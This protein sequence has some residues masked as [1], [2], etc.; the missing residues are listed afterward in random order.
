MAWQ[1]TEDGK[2]D[3]VTLS[4]DVGNIRGKEEEF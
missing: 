2:M 3:D 1:L 4:P